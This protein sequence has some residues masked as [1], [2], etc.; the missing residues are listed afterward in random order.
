MMPM[1]DNQMTDELSIQIGSL[2]KKFSTFIFKYTKSAHFAENA[3][4][5][6]PDDLKKELYILIDKISLRLLSD[7]DNF[8]GYFLLQMNRDIRFDISNPTAVY[9]SNTKYVL[10]FN[11]MIFLNLNFKQMLSA[12][13]HEILHILSMHISRTK[14]FKENYYTE[15]INLAMDITVNMY[16][17]NLPPYA[18]TLELVNFRYGLQLKPYMPLEYYIEKLQSD[19]KIE[20]NSVNGFI[21]SDNSENSD[22]SRDTDVRGNRTES[23][24]GEN[25][26]DMDSGED[27]INF[28]KEFI[29]DNENSKNNQS[30]QSNENIKAKYKNIKLDFDYQKTHEVWKDSMDVEDKTLSAFTESIIMNATKGTV[31]EY[32]NHILAYIKNSKGEL[33]WNLY[34]KRMLGTEI[35]NKKKTITRKSRRQPE[36]LDLRGELIGY[37]A[38][39]VVAIDIS[40]SI[41]DEEFVQ[42]MKE[43]INIVKNY[44]HE[45]TIIECDSEIRRTYKVKT[46]KDIKSRINVKGDTKFDP[47]FK[48]A[49][50]IHCNLLIYFTDGKG[51][52]RLQSKPNGYKTMWIISGRG[53]KLSLVESYGVIKKLSAIDKKDDLSLNDIVYGY[54][55]MNQEPEKV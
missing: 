6:T 53:D 34:L 3:R 11:P 43:V 1:E 19:L 28:D 4:V 5:V 51:E 52:E 20:Q 8:Y 40:A 50:S 16:L 18:I 12:I 46:I 2:Y 49:N 13:K 37:K 21:S 47:V 55:M 27:E 14:N 48:F 36:R 24:N 35:S 42:A 23:E 31:P 15:V 38:K 22:D 17:D 32:I 26:Q 39:I 10:C 44:K 9:F 29:K 54:S 33:P 30:N 41:S 45:I 25:V 7:K